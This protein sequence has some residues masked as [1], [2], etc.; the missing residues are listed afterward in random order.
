MHSIACPRRPRSAEAIQYQD[1]V[2]M[3][4]F[5]EET[6]RQNIAGLESEQRN[7]SQPFPI[8][9]SDGP[10]GGFPVPRAEAY[11][12]LWQ[13]SPVIF[14]GIE[15]NRDII[16]ANHGVPGANTSFHTA[17]VVISDFIISQPGDITSKGVGSAVFSM[18]ISVSKKDMTPY[19][20]DPISQA[21]FPIFDS[22]EDDRKPVAILTAWIHWK[23]YLENILPNSLTGIFAVLHNTCGSSYTYELV[24]EEVRPVG[25]GDLH[26][27]EFSDMKRSA[28]FEGVDNIADGTKDGLPLNQDHCRVSI[29]VY[30]S[31]SFY[32]IH[33]TA[34][35]II[36]TCAV[37]I[38][39]VFTALLFVFYDRLVERRQAIVL[40]KANQTNAIVSS[41]FPKNV[42]E[43]LMSNPMNDSKMNN[44]NYGHN[45]PAR[46][47]KGYLNGAQTDDIDQAPIADLFPHCTVSLYWVNCTLETAFERIST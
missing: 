20:G 18:L 16:V 2:D 24:G 39:F 12:P 38:I 27:S 13:T 17:S 26:E 35:P 4:E 1:S 30:P 10:I 46:R 22:F 25:E 11:M 3:F 36:M 42:Q 33:N 8:W 23:A 43:R 15:V 19:E 47:L 44:G 7:G 45:V 21:F 37:A 6:I 31:K 5:A 34:T 29:D 41:L 40:Y 9:T 32:N 14:G 28:S